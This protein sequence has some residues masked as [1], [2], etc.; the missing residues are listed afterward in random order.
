VETFVSTEEKI[1][2]SDESVDLALMANVLHELDGYTTLKEVYRLL[3]PKGVLAVLEWK[4]EET[5][6]G[7]PI[8]ERLTPNQTIEIVEKTG[9]KV[10]DMSPIGP[11]HYLVIAAKHA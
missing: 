10:K 8:W 4:K 3:K 5:R 11:Y 6:F 7:P 1:P 9:F 2:I